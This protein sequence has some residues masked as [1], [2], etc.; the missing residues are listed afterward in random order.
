MYKISEYKREYLVLFSSG[1]YK[2]RE[3]TRYFRIIVLMILVLIFLLVSLAGV[4]VNMYIAFHILVSNYQKTVF[5]LGRVDDKKEL[6][7]LKLLVKASYGTSTLY[8][9]KYTLHQNS[10]KS[11]HSN[12]ILC[13]YFPSPEF[14][15]STVGREHIAEF[16]SSS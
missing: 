3:K 12:L 9:I 13:W 6:L 2:L 1:W 15:I 7:N 4:S 14:C 11:F 10:V 16:F 5:D 8:N